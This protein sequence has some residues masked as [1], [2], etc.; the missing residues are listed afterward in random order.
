MLKQEPVCGLT[1]S[2]R[3]NVAVIFNRAR[4]GGSTVINIGIVTEIW[5]FD[6]T[7]L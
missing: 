6:Y 5:F 2:G 7:L 4:G 3:T 1:E